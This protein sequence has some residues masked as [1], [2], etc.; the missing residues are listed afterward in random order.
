[1]LV[2]WDILTYTYYSGYDL[3]YDKFYTT[4]PNTGQYILVLW[5]QIQVNPSIKPLASSF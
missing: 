4:T 1:M 3:V 2:H 5:I